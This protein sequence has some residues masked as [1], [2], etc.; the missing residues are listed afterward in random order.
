MLLPFLESVS[1]VSNDSLEETVLILK[2][3]ERS[4][5]NFRLPLDPTPKD[6][7]SL[8]IM[9]DG[10]SLTKQVGCGMSATLL[11]RERKECCLVVKLTTTQQH[12]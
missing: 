12:C 1:M 7:L 5:S 6:S 11:Q 3:L 10:S 4:V 2:G 9:P 8:V